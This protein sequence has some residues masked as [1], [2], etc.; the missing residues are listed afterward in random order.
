M[1][2][3]H[4]SLIAHKYSFPSAVQCPVRSVTHKLS[5]SVERNWRHTRSSWAAVADLVAFAFRRF[6]FAKLAHHPLSEQ[7]RHTVRSDATQPAS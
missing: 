7:A 6:R 4:R 2:F 5:G 1:R 3:D